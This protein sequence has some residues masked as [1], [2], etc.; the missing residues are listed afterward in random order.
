MK[1]T[2][3][4]GIVFLG[5]LAFSQS[6]NGTISGRLIDENRES[7]MF[8]KVEVFSSEDSLMSTLL[9]GAES[10]FD[11]TFRISSVPVGNYALR[12]S[13]FIEGMDTVQLENIEVKANMIIALGSILMRRAPNSEFPCICPPKNDPVKIEID[14]FGRST[15]IKSEDIRRP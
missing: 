7:V 2:I 8:A 5:H 14:P 15:T 3:L 4:F 1:T 13:N 12:I 11:G 10:D 9:A 6:G